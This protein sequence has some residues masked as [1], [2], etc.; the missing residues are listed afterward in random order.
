MVASGP[1]SGPTKLPS[2]NRL[3]PI[4]PSNGALMSV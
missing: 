1:L 3:R 2:L 4:L